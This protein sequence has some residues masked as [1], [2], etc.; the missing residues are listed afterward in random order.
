MLALAYKYRLLPPLNWGDD[1]EAQIR[2]KAAAFWNRLVEIEQAHVET[3][4]EIIG[5]DPT[6]A[7]AAARV[8]AIVTEIAALRLSRKEARRTTRKAAAPGEDQDIRR[9]QVA[10]QPRRDELR[11][12][13]VTS[14][15][16]KAADL[17]AASA[18]R[19]VD[20][21]LA[22]QAAAADGLWWGNYNAIL[23]SFETAAAVARKTGAVLH[24]RRFD[25]EG[26]LTNQLQ[27]GATPAEILAG[28]HPQVRFEFV[29]GPSPKRQMHL[30]VC[31]FIEGRTNKRMVEFPMIMHRPLP[32][33]A[34]IQSVTVHRRRVADR[35][36]WHAVFDLRCPQPPLPE[37]SEPQVAA[38][39]FGWRK[40]GDDA[41]RVATILRGGKTH[42]IMVPPAILRGHALREQNQG[43]MRK[44]IDATAAWLGTLPWASAPESLVGEASAIMASQQP[45]GGHIDWLRQVW[46]RDAPE[47]CNEELDTIRAFGRRWRLYRRNDAAGRR[48]SI[49]AREYHYRDQIWRLLQGCSTVVM[50]LHDMRETAKVEGNDLPRPARH[51]R[52]LAAPSVFR[53]ALQQWAAKQGVTIAVDSQGHDTCACHG[54]PFGRVDRAALYWACP[55]SGL[56]LDQDQDFCRGMHKRFLSGEGAQP[57][58]GSRRT[59]VFRPNRR[60][61]ADP[62]DSPRP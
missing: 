2:N 42:F 46:E 41:L 45:R 7:E 5:N 12:A 6:V 28:S 10:L 35:T 4:R 14:A 20:I 61:S 37:R 22:R 1:C 53:A 33:D 34:S 32:V 47:W 48:W 55:V 39:N 58:A 40:V 57:T 16:A 9:L 21:R 13:R 54:H 27:G 11:A 49:D 31:A 51:N 43:T 15:A 23:Q 18:K 56:P 60:R 26:R 8:E 19:F 25:A 50:N 59:P 30:V 29:G 24:P 17:K 52:V 62:G 44:D 36:E 38:V 3:V